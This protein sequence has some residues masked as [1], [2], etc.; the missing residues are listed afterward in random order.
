MGT[1]CDFCK[2][3]KPQVWDLV[4][5]IDMKPKVKSRPSFSRLGGARTDQATHDAQKIFA[6]QMYKAGARTFEV[7]VEVE[8][9]VL[10]RVPLKLVNPMPRGDVDNYAKLVLDAIQPTIIRDDTLVKKLTVSK[11]YSMQDGYVI[12]IRKADF[13][14]DLPMVNSFIRKVLA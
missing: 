7:P 14:D 12:K 9:E 1:E 13:G 5:N 11:R 2:G 10:F 8:I 3:R 4:C 6:S